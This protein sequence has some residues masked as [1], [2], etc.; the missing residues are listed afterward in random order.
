MKKFLRSI[1]TILLAVT[2]LFAIG[3][4]KDKNDSSDSAPQEI[5]YTAEV[6]VIEEVDSFAPCFVKDFIFGNEHTSEYFKA[7]N[8]S[9][10]D[11]NKMLVISIDGEEWTDVDVLYDFMPEGEYEI[12]IKTTPQMVI[13]EENED[14]VIVEKP[15]K[16]D[17][18]VTVNVSASGVN[19]Y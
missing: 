16:R 15:Y 8:K 14:G 3:C 7:L 9:V 6:L 1:C 10:F 19:K 4:G 11:F 2:T 17:I 12:N 18:T 13:A 5:D